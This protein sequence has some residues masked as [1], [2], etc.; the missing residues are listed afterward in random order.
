MK[1]MGSVWAY[2]RSGITTFK[3]YK[4]VLYHSN[5]YFDGNYYHPDTSY[6]K[7]LDDNGTPIRQIKCATEEGI[8]YYNVLWYYSKTD[9]DPL[10]VFANVEEYIEKNEKVIENGRFKLIDVLKIL[11]ERQ[12]ITIHVYAPCG[13]FSARAIV[14]M[15]AL[16]DD[17]LQSRVYKFKTVEND[18][19]IHIYISKSKIKGE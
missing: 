5:A 12:N 10:A 13:R 16:S 3:E 8:P 15:E 18:S 4:A 2:V 1:C 9:L 14:A 6:L 11:D 19:D 7:L 17:I